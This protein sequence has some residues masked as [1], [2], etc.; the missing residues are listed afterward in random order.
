MTPASQSKYILYQESINVF[1]ERN[2]RRKGSREIDL[3]KLGCV[4]M[5]KFS[6]KCCPC[7]INLER[8]RREGLQGC[9]DQGK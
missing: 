5:Q 4:I 7:N 8:K 3:M 2:D 9:K 6:I 1:A